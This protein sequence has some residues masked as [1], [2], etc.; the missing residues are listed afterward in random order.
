MVEALGNLVGMERLV[1]VVG[2]Y[3]VE[4]SLEPNKVVDSGVAFQE[5]KDCTVGMEVALTAILRA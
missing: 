5:H 1:N 3:R 4:A 2:S